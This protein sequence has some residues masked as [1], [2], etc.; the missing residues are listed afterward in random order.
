MKTKAQWWNEWREDIENCF[1]Q[2]FD[3]HGNEIT[4]TNRDKFIEACWK[5]FDESQT[6]DVLNDMEIRDG[7]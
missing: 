5:S 6:N 4:E 7:N 3:M 2:G 1:D